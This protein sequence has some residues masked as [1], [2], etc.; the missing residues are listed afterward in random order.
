MTGRN[1]FQSLRDAMTPAQRANAATKAAALREEM[2]LSELRQARLLTQETLGETLHVGQAA[3]AKME[4]RADM[5]V[6]NLRRFIEAM[7]GELHIVAQF[8]EGAVTI[9]NFAAIGD[10]PPGSSR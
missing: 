3:V 7:G 9:S 2:S 1:S 10:L 4:K 8:P 6:S 5:Y